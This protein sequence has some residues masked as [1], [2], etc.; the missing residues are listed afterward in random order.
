M[1]K[2]VYLFCA[3]ALLAVT[4]CDAHK[5]FPDTSM[6]IGHVLCTDGQVVPLSE[7]GSKTAIGVVFRINQDSGEGIAY[8]VYI[9]DISPVEF[10]DS[11]GV[12]QGTSADVTAHDGN[13]NTYSLYSNTSVGSPLAKA[14]FDMWAYGQSAYVPSVAQMHSLSQALS[15]INP[16]L[17]TV[18]GTAIPQTAQDCWYWTSTEVKGQENDKAWLY[19][20]STGAIQETPKNQAHRCRPIITIY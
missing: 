3:I 14:V 20:I 7:L 5:D 10:S 13:A 11:L 12:A 19:S 2:L 18:G 1:K 4:S 16:V 8:A 15:Q 6:K 17:E 9:K